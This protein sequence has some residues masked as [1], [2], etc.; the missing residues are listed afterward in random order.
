MT[1]KHTFQYKVFEAAVSRACLCA[2]TS[3]PSCFRVQCQRPSSP[4]ASPMLRTCMTVRGAQDPFP[5]GDKWQRCCARVLCPVPL[6]ASTCR[7][8]L[9]TCR[10]LGGRAQPCPVPVCFDGHVENEGGHPPWQGR[11]GNPSGHIHRGAAWVC[12]GQRAAGRDPG[13]T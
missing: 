6:D 13:R 1:S 12:R 8:P 11:S 9:V 4:A 2:G 10:S 3:R 5:L 7:G